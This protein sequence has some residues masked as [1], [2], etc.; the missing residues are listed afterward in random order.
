[1]RVAFAH[2]NLAGD[3]SG[4]SSWLLRLATDL[5][6]NDIEVAVYLTNYLSEQESSPSPLELALRHAGV[7]I[8]TSPP[9]PTL[10]KN[11]A[12]TL[13]FLNAWQPDV[14]LPQCKGH[15]YVAAA[16]AGQRGLPWALTLHSDDEDYW[17]VIDSLPPNSHGG[18][19]VCVSRH[20]QL[21]LARRSA[22]TE[23]VLIP[24]GVPIPRQ[25]TSF[26]QSPFRI[27]YCGRLWEHQK[28]ISLV[29]SALIK[30]CQ[31]PGRDLQA[32]VIGDGYCRELCEQQVREAG[33]EDR[34]SFLGQQ[35][36]PIIQAHFLHSQAILLMSDFEGLPVAFLEGMA[37]GLVPVARAIPSGIPELV[38]QGETGLLVSDDPEE[39]AQALASLADDQELWQRCSKEARNLVQGLYN[40][41]RSNQQWHDLLLRLSSRSR[42]TYPINGLQGVRLSDLSPLLKAAYERKRVWQQLG[43]RHRLPT[44]VATFKGNVKRWF[45]PLAKMQKPS[46]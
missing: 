35:P 8:H 19:A 6:L 9:G 41:E 5:R 20:I 28:R 7:E 12:A 46:R 21:E 36:F 34:I 11:V 13:A 42:V 33:L 40:Q 27:I 24:Y 2:Y 30:A 15:H 39:A 4:V 14:F 26:N 10:R 16:I 38:R 1:M 31:C 37:A 3:I 44:A 25:A 43:L 23:A 22:E 45:T 17:A 18:I 29:I 32:T